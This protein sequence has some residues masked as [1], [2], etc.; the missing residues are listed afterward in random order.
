MHFFHGLH[1]GPCWF[2]TAELL[3]SC[4]AIL[5]PELFILKMV[6]AMIYQ[7]EARIETLKWN[8]I[9]SNSLPAAGSE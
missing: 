1:A 5:P 2:Q 6:R 9:T 3:S 7:Q 4:K 8:V